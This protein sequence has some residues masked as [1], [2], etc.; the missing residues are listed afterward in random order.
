MKLQKQT[1]IINAIYKVMDI[2][3]TSQKL[4]HDNMANFEI[5]YAIKVLNKK[6]KIASKTLND[7]GIETK[8]FGGLLA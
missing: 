4:Y 5:E 2:D 6:R 8:N 1:E 3:K 7:L